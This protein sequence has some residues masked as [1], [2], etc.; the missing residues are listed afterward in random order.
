MV[1]GADQSCLWVG[2]SDDG[3]RIGPS[4]SRAPLPRPSPRLE[5]RSR[6]YPT[7]S[8]ECNRPAFAVT[9]IVI[10]LIAT[11]AR[12]PSP[13]SIAADVGLHKRQP[14]KL[15][16]GSPTTLGTHSTTV[17]PPRIHSKHARL[18]IA[19]L[20]ARPDAHPPASLPRRAPL[21]QDTRRLHRCTPT[22]RCPEGYLAPSTA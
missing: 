8:T 9:S 7:A 22:I 13:L 20:T 3:A 11:F 1:A 2:R 15:H 18:C 19:S 16:P 6:G 14:H 17:S 21:V 5:H 10:I 4:K 12:S